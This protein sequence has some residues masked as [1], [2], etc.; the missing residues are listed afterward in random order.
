MLFVLQK[1]VIECQF[2]D[3]I[4]TDRIDYSSNAIRNE[5]MLPKQCVGYVV[6]QLILIISFRIH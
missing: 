2:H 6:N 4:G 1:R 5:F 3:Q